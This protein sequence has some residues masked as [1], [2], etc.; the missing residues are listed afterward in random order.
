[1]NP[2]TGQVPGGALQPK[3]REDAGAPGAAP[4]ARA[5]GCGGDGAAAL[6]ALAVPLPV[7]AGVLL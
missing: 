6:R 5:R 7:P 1:V 2:G 4:A 3:V